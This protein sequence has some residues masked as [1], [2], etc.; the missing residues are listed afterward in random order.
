MVNVGK[1]TVRPMDA[2]GKPLRIPTINQS[3]WLMTQVKPR[4]FRFVDAWA[5]SP[6]TGA[7]AWAPVRL[8][9]GSSLQ[10]I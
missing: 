6:T 1:Y 7:A 5:A 4:L 10:N 3:G 2:M 8:V 9:K